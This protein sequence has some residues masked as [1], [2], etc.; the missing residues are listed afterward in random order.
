MSKTANL[1]EVISHRLHRL[2]KTGSTRDSEQTRD[3]SGFGFLGLIGSR[4]P[5]SLR[6]CG[7]PAS[8]AGFPSAGGT[9]EKS[10]GRTF[11]RIPRRVISAANPQLCPFWRK[12]GGGVL[13][14]TKSL[15]TE[16]RIKCLLLQNL[17]ESRKT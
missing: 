14:K 11:P 7:N 9:V 16:S 6:K 17:V 4:E 13:L 8:F 15:F 2:G 1:P 10:G 5:S 12:C 3:W